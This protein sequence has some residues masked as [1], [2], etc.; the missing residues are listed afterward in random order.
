MYM[1]LYPFLATAKK[2]ILDTAYWRNDRR[3]SI[4]NSLRTLDLPIFFIQSKDD[5]QIPFEHVYR[6]AQTIPDEFVTEWWIEPGR[7]KHAWH[8]LYVSD[9]YR[10]YTH[11]FFQE[12]LEKK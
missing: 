6:L 8:F 4:F 12:V 7:S 2:L 1:I 5:T 3:L 10:H 9:E 11:D